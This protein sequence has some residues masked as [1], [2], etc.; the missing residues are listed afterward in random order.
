MRWRRS[1]LAGWCPCNVCGG[2]RSVSWEMGVDGG[3]RVRGGGGV[4][5]VHGAVSVMV[6]AGCGG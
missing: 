2:G 1:W 3:G 6:A 4:L 5:D